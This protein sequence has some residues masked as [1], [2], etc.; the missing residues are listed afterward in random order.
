M[1][2]LLAKYMESARQE[3]EAKSSSTTGKAVKS[4]KNKAAPRIIPPVKAIVQEQ[5]LAAVVRPGRVLKRNRCVLGQPKDY[6][7]SQLMVHL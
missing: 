1:G 7:H 3:H 2:E 4:T 6:E 5:K